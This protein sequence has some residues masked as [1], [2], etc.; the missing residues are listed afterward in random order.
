V[1]IRWPFRI[2]GAALAVLGLVIWSFFLAGVL[3]SGR[4][5]T[6]AVWDEAFFTLS[7]PLFVLVVGVPSV[8]GGFPP[9]FRRVIPEFFRSLLR[10]NRES[11][12]IDR[13][14]WRGGYFYVFVLAPIAIVVVLGFGVMCAI[15][16]WLSGTYWIAG[17]FAAATLFVVIAEIND[18][19]RLLRSATID[20]E[21]AT[22]TGK[23]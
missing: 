20:R 13:F 3:Q 7:A 17:V 8:S 22:C 18:L 16:A 14:G 10:A 12:L 5:G 21:C 6:G 1:I 9:W 19:A 15:P 11:W 2:A 4:L 23:A